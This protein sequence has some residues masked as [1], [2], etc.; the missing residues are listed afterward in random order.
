[1]V[2]SVQSILVQI[3]LD[4]FGQFSSG[5]CGQSGSDY[6]FGSVQAIL[7]CSVQIVLVR[8]V[9]IIL[10]WISLDSTLSTYRR[11]EIYLLQSLEYDQDRFGFYFIYKQKVRSPLLAV[12]KYSL[13]WSGLNVIFLTSRALVVS[14]HG[15]F[16]HPS[17]EAVWIDVDVNWRSSLV[18][19]YPS[20][21]ASWMRCGC[22]S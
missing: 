9:W 4:Y 18:P 19:V 6:L 11:L 16:I 3:S 10:V 15:G 22:Y 5:Y 17:T 1:L 2:S 20:S 7:V 14:I 13:D 12:L 21:K 8:S